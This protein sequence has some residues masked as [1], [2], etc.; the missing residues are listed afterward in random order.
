MSNASGCVCHYRR[1]SA[2]IRDRRRLIFLIRLQVIGKKM[3]EGME[4]RTDGQIRPAEIIL[5]I[6]PII[7]FESSYFYFILFY[8]RQFNSISISIS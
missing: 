2:M 4:E 6:I 8:L 5:F 3:E 1:L 7:L